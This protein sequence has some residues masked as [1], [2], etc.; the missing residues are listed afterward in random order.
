MSRVTVTA[1]RPE[2][3]TSAGAESFQ[4][5]E[6]RSSELIH[7]SQW[8]TRIIAA[9]LAGATELGIIIDIEPSARR[10]LVA[11]FRAELDAA[12]DEIERLAGEL[13]LEKTARTMI[14]QERDQLKSHELALVAEIQRLQ[15]EL[16]RSQHLAAATASDNRE[17]RELLTGERLANHELAGAVADANAALD[18][19]RRAHREHLIAGA[20]SLGRSRSYSAERRAR[21]EAGP[22]RESMA[23]AELRFRLDRMEASYSPEHHSLAGDVGSIRAELRRLDVRFDLVLD[24]LDDLEA[25]P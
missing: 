12:G 23:I 5:R 1:R 3:S 22:T 14:A 15:T 17:L 21:S 18:L 16:V 9:E 13:G 20:A 2:P 19:E 8:N 10:E 24:R 6:L 11:E 25:R 4:I 7:G